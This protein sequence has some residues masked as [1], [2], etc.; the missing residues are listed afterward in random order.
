MPVQGASARMA[1]KG[2]LSGSGRVASAT[3]SGSPGPRRR[4][5]C[6]A[7]C[8]WRSRATRRAAGASPRRIA[9]LPPGAAQQSRI[10]GRA[11]GSNSSGK[12]CEA[13]SWMAIAPEA[14][15]ADRVT[16]PRST[17]SAAGSKRPGRVA[18]PSWRRDCTAAAGGRP[19]ASRSAACGAA[20]AK[21]QMRRTTSS[22][23]RASQRASSQAGCEVSMARRVMGS[24]SRAS[25]A[26][27]GGRGRCRSTAL[28][29]AAVFGPAALANST[30]S[31]TAASSGTR[32]RKWI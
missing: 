25:S 21:A 5:S 17:R 2:R 13:S 12:S 3:T 22:P 1:S 15:N 31:C 29:K 6:R 4:R 27:S 23:Q 11:A 14:A 20:L 28:T 10:R 8:G 19:L 16:S 32:S 7:R 18:M 9:V 30:L 26:A 24:G